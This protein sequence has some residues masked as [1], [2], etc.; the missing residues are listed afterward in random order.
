MT[1]LCFAL[2]RLELGIAG[3]VT[4]GSAPDNPNAREATLGSAR[5]TPAELASPRASLSHARR[6]PHMLAHQIYTLLRP[7]AVSQTL[8]M[9]YPAL[10]Y[11]TCRQ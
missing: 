3:S 10:P 8:H 11:P 1:F 7:F 9:E 2:L 6:R 4:C 5:T